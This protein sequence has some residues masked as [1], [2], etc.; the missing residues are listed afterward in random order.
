MR[1]WVRGASRCRGVLLCFVF[2]ASVCSAVAALGQQTP[3]RLPNGF[4]V[5]RPI[6]PRTAPNDFSRFDFVKPGL[7]NALIKYQTEPSMGTAAGVLKFFSTDFYPMT[8]AQRQMLFDAEPDLFLSVDVAKYELVMQTRIKVGAKPGL[9]SNKQ[10]VSDDDVTNLTASPDLLVDEAVNEE[11][12][13]KILQDV[14]ALYQKGVP[15]G[16][17]LTASDLQ[18]EFLSPTKAW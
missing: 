5:F 10:F 17:Q 13:K 18:F 14:V 16:Q 15:P 2:L 11:K 1:C 12:A 6:E 3:A 8:P 7:R 9:D 4:I